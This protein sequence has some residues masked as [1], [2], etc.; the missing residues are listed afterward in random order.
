[1]ELAVGFLHVSCRTR[2]LSLGEMYNT[3]HIKKG[4]DEKTLEFL[5][6]TQPQQH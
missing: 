4:M 1:M 2:C 6:H 3:R 5:L